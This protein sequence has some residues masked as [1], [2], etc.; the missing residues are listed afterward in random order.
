MGMSDFFTN[1]TLNCEPN[2][3]DLILRSIKE[4]LTKYPSSLRQLNTQLKSI[5]V[6]PWNQNQM[7]WIPLWMP[8]L[9]G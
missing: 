4:D 1:D 8:S 5:L 6:K 9:S 3:V 2:E 7:T